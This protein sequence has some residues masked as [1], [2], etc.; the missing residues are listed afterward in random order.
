MWEIIFIL[1]MI[2]VGVAISLWDRKKNESD[3]SHGFSNSSPRS[4]RSKTHGFLDADGSEYK[5]GSQK[6][7]EEKKRKKQEC[8]R[9]EWYDDYE[10]Y[11]DEDGN[12]HSLDYDN[13]CDECDDYHEE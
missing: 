10:T 12:E 6:R 11:T 1:A 5:T 7:R 8:A 4:K 13:Y 2:I 9:Q 3:A